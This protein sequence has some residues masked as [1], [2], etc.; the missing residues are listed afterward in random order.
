ME[1]IPAPSQTLQS[2]KPQVDAF[3]T[4]ASEILK[5][6]ENA[7]SPSEMTILIGHDGGIHMVAGSDWPL[8]SLSLHHGAKEAFRVSQINGLAKVEGRAGTRTCIIQ[9]VTPAETARR[10]LESR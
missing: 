3:T 8:D 7:G 2:D 6:A 9:A 10:L 4:R 5:A 1:I